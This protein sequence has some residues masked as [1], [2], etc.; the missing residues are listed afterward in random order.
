MERDIHGP[1]NAVTSTRETVQAAAR[2]LL[3]LTISA[4]VTAGGVLLFFALVSVILG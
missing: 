1:A 2:V 3:P 4:A